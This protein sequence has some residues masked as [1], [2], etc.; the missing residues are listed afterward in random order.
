MEIGGFDN[1]GQILPLSFLAACRKAVFKKPFGYF[2]PQKN[3]ELEV[4]LHV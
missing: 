3:P 4:A 2:S 1:F